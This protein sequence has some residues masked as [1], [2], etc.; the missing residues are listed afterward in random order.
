MP[1]LIVLAGVPGSGKSTWA[2]SIFDLKYS[3]VSSDTIRTRLYGSLKVAHEGANP[4]KAESSPNN[5]EVFD[6]F[7]REVEEKLRHGVDVIADATHLSRKSRQRMLEI[8]WKT[9]AKAHLVIFKNLLEADF[10]NAS[11]DDDAR[12][13]AEVMRHMEWKFYDTLA[14]HMQEPWDSVMKVEGFR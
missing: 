8:A 12:V 7:H 9:S 13:P 3:I 10:R 6:I 5:K 4:G 2:H 11:R 14:E 1:N